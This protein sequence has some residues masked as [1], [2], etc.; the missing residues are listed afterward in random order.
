MLMI[1]KKNILYVESKVQNCKSL[2]CK[3]I[4]LYDDCQ[5]FCFYLGIKEEAAFNVA[6]VELGGHLPIK[7]KLPLEEFIKTLIIKK[8]NTCTLIIDMFRNQ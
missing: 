4:S 3:K 7:G 8:Y 6:V 2:L 5:W 1:V